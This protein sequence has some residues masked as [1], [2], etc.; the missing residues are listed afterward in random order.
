MRL[1]TDQIRVI[2]EVILDRDPKAEILLFGS[3]VNDSVKGGDIDLLVLSD[4]LGFGDLWP[5]RSQILD[6]IGWQKL[7]ILI[8]PQIGEVSAIGRIAMM[9]GVPL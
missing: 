6:Q 5:L 7:D 1:S 9:E 3:R 2:R 4:R 8:E